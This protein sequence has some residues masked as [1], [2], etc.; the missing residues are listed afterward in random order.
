MKKSYTQSYLIEPSQGVWV[1]KNLRTYEKSMKGPAPLMKT[2]IWWL[3]K[4]GDLV[5]FR[6]PLK[7][8]L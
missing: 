3:G 1:M 6:W 5:T 8:I 7:E 2:N 4:W